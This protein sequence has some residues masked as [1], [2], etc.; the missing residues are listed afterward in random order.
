M[1]INYYYDT[2]RV[3]ILFEKLIKEMLNIALNFISF[4]QFV[5]YKCGSIRVIYVNCNP[6]V[7]IFIHK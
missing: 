5:N 1:I 7:L 3:T 6:F 4:I 2:L